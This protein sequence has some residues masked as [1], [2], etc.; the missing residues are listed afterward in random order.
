LAEF[1]LG[2]YL[3]C[4][5][6]GGGAGE[7]LGAGQKGK[8]PGGGE[9]KVAS[10]SLDIP[11]GGMTL[12]LSNGGGEKNKTPRGPRP[13]G[14]RFKQRGN[15]GK[16]RG[17]VSLPGPRRGPQKPAPPGRLNFHFLKNQANRGGGPGLRSRSRPPNKIIRCWGGGG[18]G[19]VWLV[20]PHPPF[21]RFFLGIQCTFTRGPEFGR[22]R[23]VLLLCT[24]EYG[25]VAPGCNPPFKSNLAILRD[26]GTRAFPS[27]PYEQHRAL[28]A[29]WLHSD[30]CALKA[31]KQTHCRED[32]TTEL[33]RGF[34]LLQRTPRLVFPIDGSIF[35][36]V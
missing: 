4:K 15:T 33:R 5:F 32:H 16:N 18:G 12:R 30:E 11:R 19:T 7:I 35:G 14:G 36:Q 23:G 10:F 2:Q 3:R 27:H 24:H 34:G 26:G 20:A 29:G 21:R 6:S 17:F 22:K 1:S 31:D 8:A 25:R 9:G 13:G 28:L